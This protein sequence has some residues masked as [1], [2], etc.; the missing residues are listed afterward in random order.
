VAGITLEQAEAKLAL[1]MAA[2]DA[3]SANQTYTLD[4]GGSRR[5]VTR[6]DAAE[7]SRNIEKWDNWCRKLSPGANGRTGIQA[8][9][10]ITP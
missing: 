1:W 9:G 4:F 3:V 5:T 8:M 10:V 6:A 7:I 2:D